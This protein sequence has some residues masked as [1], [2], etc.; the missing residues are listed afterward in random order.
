MHLLNTS[1]NDALLYIA[2]YRP[3]YEPAYIGPMCMNLTLDAPLAHPPGPA[4]GHEL[5]H[6]ARLVCSGYALIRPHMEQGYM[7]LA[8]QPKAWRWGHRSY[9][10]PASCPCNQGKCHISVL[11]MESIQQC[12]KA[13]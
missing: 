13:S 2:I 6:Y 12:M 3:A 5:G 11:G 1:A 9:N 10:P 8:R 7:T 4:L